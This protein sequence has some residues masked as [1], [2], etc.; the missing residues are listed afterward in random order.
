MTTTCPITQLSEVKTFDSKCIPS[1]MTLQRVKTFYWKRN[2]FMIHSSSKCCRC[3]PT[4]SHAKRHAV[5]TLQ[6][7]AGLES[8]IEAATHFVQK[9]FQDVACE[10]LMQKMHPTNWTQQVSLES[11]KRLYPPLHTYLHISYNTPVT[12]YTTSR[13]SILPQEGVT[14]GDNAATTLY[15]IFTQPP[16]RVDKNHNFFK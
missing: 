13:F 12:L 11:T 3:I 2:P 7:C 6:T 9:R 10:C 8:G 15:F 14:L 16:I 4:C 1:I 5:V